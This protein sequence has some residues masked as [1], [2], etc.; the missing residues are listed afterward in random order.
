MPVEIEQWRAEN[1]NFIAHL[2]GVIMK[3]VTSHLG[4]IR[5]KRPESC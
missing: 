4:L 3:V 5:S 1:G 2:H